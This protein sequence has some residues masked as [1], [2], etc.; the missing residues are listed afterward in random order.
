MEWDYEQGDDD[1]QGVYESAKHKRK[2]RAKE[3]S[4]LKGGQ[5]SLGQAAPY[6]KTKATSST[7]SKNT[8]K[9]Q[10]AQQSPIRGRQRVRRKIRPSE[11]IG[12]SFKAGDHVEVLDEEYGT[13]R[14]TRSR[15]A[16]NREGLSIL[17]FD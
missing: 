16:R 1:G 6:Q 14:H 10:S 3:F 7:M 11:Q 8:R 4:F 5:R 12:K 2:T 13:R 17:F 9:G 15:S